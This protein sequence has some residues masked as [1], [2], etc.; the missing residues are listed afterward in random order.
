MILVLVAVGIVP[1]ICV[2]ATLGSTKWR[3]W[4]VALPLLYLAA[5]HVCWV[6]RAD[7]NWGEALALW[8]S[9]PGDWGS[10]TVLMILNAV[11]ADLAICMFGYWMLTSL[12]GRKGEE[13]GSVARERR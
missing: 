1:A 2:V 5:I 3:I 8:V 9:P 4:L 12:T 7:W 13:S 10:R 6:W 11:A